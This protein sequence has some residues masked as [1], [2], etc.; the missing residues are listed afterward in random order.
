MAIP[1][2]LTTRAKQRAYLQRT[3]KPITMPDLSRKAPERSE[4]TPKTDGE[5]S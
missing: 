2:C 4:V 5:Q 1:A 3:T